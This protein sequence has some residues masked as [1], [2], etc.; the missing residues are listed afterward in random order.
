MHLTVT[1]A[2]T[3]SDRPT[4]LSRVVRIERFEDM[5]TE[6]IG[7]AS[8]IELLVDFD[9]FLLVQS[10]FGAVFLEGRSICRLA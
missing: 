10:T 3:A 2:E 6:L 9:E 5:R 4:D 7:F 1:S 8:R